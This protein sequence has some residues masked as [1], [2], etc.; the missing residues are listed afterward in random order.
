ML[1]RSTLLLEYT[2]RKTGRRC[3]FPV[4]Y[5]TTGA[6]LVVLAG[7]PASKTWWRHFDARPQAVTVHLRGQA[8]AMTARRLE[9]GTVEYVQASQAY[10][11]RFP[12]SRVSSD[13]PVLALQGSPSHEPPRASGLAMVV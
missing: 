10:L 11:A 9:A 3:V 1:S 2:T 12:K 13:S 7:H 4:Q 5:A 8:V 6:D